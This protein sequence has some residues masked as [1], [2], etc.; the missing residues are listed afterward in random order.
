MGFS[1]NQGDVYSYTAPFL[2]VVG[3]GHNIHC[4][5]QTIAFLRLFKVLFPE[6]R[7]WNF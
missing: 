3:G 2:E 1:L 7:L 6:I 5:I 4:Y